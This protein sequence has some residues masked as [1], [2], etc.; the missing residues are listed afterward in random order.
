MPCFGRLNFRKKTKEEYLEKEFKVV[1][2]EIKKI[3]LYILR[4]RHQGELDISLDWLEQIVAEAFSL[5]KKLTEKMEFYRSRQRV[6]SRVDPRYDLEL[7]VP[8]LQNEEPYYTSIDGFYC[9]PVETSNVIYRPPMETSDKVPNH[10][11]SSEIVSNIDTN[12]SL[13]VIPRV[14][15]YNP[16]HTYNKLSHFPTSH[17]QVYDTNINSIFQNITDIAVSPSSG[18]CS[19]ELT[20]AAEEAPYQEITCEL[21]NNNNYSNL[22]H[23]TFNDQPLIQDTAGFIKT[24]IPAGNLNDQKSFNTYQ[25][26]TDFV[27]TKYDHTNY[28]SDI[29]Y[30]EFNDNLEDIEP[31]IGIEIHHGTVDNIKKPKKAGDNGT[32]L[33]TKLQKIHR[34]STSGRKRLTEDE[35]K[36]SR[37]KT[38]SR[39]YNRTKSRK[40]KIYEKETI[41]AK[42]NK[43]LKDE[44]KKLGKMFHRFKML[45]AKYCTQIPAPVRSQIES[46]FNKVAIGS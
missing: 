27:D 7:Q 14:P 36:L 23:L 34:K 6:E 35:I 16:C 33:A 29:Q 9:S 41:L 11:Y 18:Y 45:Y 42:E 40:N 39:H 19:D 21:L 31:T 30:K 28:I 3:W 24:I 44:W 32:F 15:F 4:A 43:S 37:K 20:E 46:R 8:E 12:E 26:T 17:S 25:N 2:K 5:K 10:T 38:N 22:P 13:R 1:L